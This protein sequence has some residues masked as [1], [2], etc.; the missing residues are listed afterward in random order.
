MSGNGRIEYALGGDFGVVVGVLAAN[1][2]GSELVTAS[3]KLDKV[4]QGPDYFFRPLHITALE[5]PLTVAEVVVDREPVG[6][7]PA[8]HVVDVVSMAKRDLK[9]G[10]KLDGFGGFTTYGLLGD[11][12]KAA[13]FVPIGLAQ[14]GRLNDD[15][16]IDQPIPVAAVEFNEDGPLVRLWRRQTAEMDNAAA[17]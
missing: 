15:V 6:G 8:Q 12:G 9:S 10:E 16:A 4:D 11:A 5:V 2:L 7:A 3:L 13:D 17:H 1:A 14:D